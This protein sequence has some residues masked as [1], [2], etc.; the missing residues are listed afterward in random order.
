MSLRSRLASW[1]GGQRRPVAAMDFDFPMT[2][3]GGGMGTQ[4]DT[5][6]LLR[7]SMGVADTA[8]RAIANRVSSLEPQV[9][10]KRRVRDGTEIEEVLDDHPLKDLLDRPHPNFTRSQLMRLTTQWIVTVGEGYWLKV[11]NRLG[12]P[13][14]LH[15]IPPAKV[16]PIVS[17]G[18]VQAYGVQNGQG[19]TVELAADSIIRFFFPDPESPWQSEG[20]LGP[21]GL[22]ADSLKFSGQHL[23]SHYQHDATPKTWLEA[24]EQAV[25]FQ[26]EEAERFWQ[27]W[28]KHY[29]N[30]AGD[31]AG[32]PAILPTGYK[33]ILAALQSGADITPL[34]DHWRDDM[35]M[36][37]GTPRSILGQVVSGDRSSAET[38]Q[39][40]FD[41]HTVLPIASMIAD[42]ITLQLARDFDP[43]IFMDWEPFVSADKE[44]DLKNDAQD[45][46][47]KVR[48]VN[49]VREDRGLDPVDWG[50]EP[51]GTFADQVFDPENFGSDMPPD[52]PDAIDD[53][54]D[55][56]D[57][58]RSRT[59][60]LQ[61]SEWQRQVH[62]ERK[63]V[64]AFLRAMRRLFAEQRDSV[65]TRL[66]LVTPRARVSVGE[67]F[68]PAEWVQRFATVVEPVR[69]T[70]YADILAESLES[71]GISSDFIFTEQM[72]DMLRKQGASLVT[73]ANRTTKNR[74]RDELE[75]ATAQGE[76]V[77]QIA[78]RVRS[79]FKGRRDNARTIA[80]TEVLKASQSAQLESFSQAG[81]E[82]RQW[83]TSRDANVRDQHVMAEGQVVAKGESF[84]LGDLERADAPGIG[85]G[86]STLSAGN[87]I[88]C[89]CFV[90]P[91]FLEES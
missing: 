17:G 5:S 4:P 22:T 10:T 69:V 40:V 56:D 89:R 63:F 55:D 14:Q 74:L 57:D 82:R 29:H 25:P 28:G 86:G 64:P 44:H 32:K 59:R 87:S 85:A 20:Y 54:E 61:Q 66:V 65:L 91:V 8:T 48:S 53:P 1:I 52:D 51:I 16:K 58:D 84:V 15:P 30:R 49:Q 11:G 12:V 7:E 78:R 43:S 42:T 70:A 38:N 13:M 80:R 41:L 19:Q 9:K 75:V 47:L 60:S 62:R 68:D 23:K 71:L 37:F 83:N 24:G 36:G 72:R 34:L 81:V 27:F 2:V 67:V 79:V 90:T 46:T 76:S 6:L 77:D 88:N 26:P 31:Q 3:F 45:L 35:L 73:H 21:S 50:E 39:F 33:L 18:V